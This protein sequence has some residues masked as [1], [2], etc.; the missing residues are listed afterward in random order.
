[1]CGAD[2]EHGQRRYVRQF[3]QVCADQGSAAAAVVP[4]KAAQWPARGQLG[5]LANFRRHALPLLLLLSFTLLPLHSIC[6]A[7]DEYSNPFRQHQGVNSFQCPSEMTSTVPLTTL[8][9]VWSSI[10]Y[11]GP[12]ILAAHLSALG[13]VF[14]GRSGLS[15]CG[16]IEKSTT[17]SVSSPPVGGF[18][19]TK[20]SPIRGV[21][22]MLPALSPTQIAR[23]DGNR[24][25]SPDCRIQ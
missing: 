11:A 5:S 25:A 7:Y 19:W 23:S 24:S 22:T 14:S 20:S 10:A 13:R 16:K 15:R 6:C 21:I 12:P 1:M 9:A 2:A 3:L 18:H 4:Q 8:M 17:P